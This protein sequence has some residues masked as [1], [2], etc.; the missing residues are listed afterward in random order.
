MLQVEWSIS[1][2]C[3][4]AFSSPVK[5]GPSPRHTPS[6]GFYLQKENA[7]SELTLKSCS[8]SSQS[9]I[10][11]EKS[12]PH[13]I[14][15]GG[16][17]ICPVLFETSPAHFVDLAQAYS[18]QPTHTLVQSIKTFLNLVDLQPSLNNREI[19]NRC[20]SFLGCGGVFQPLMVQGVDISGSQA[21]HQ[22]P[23]AQSNMDDST[24]LD[25]P[26]ARTPS[27]GAA[28]PCQG[29]SLQQPPRGHQE[30]C[31]LEGSKPDNPM[32]RD[33]LSVVHIPGVDNW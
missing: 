21:P 28:R 25:I 9:E 20:Q 30:S 1:K 17:A 11:H 3:S 4:P 29:Y 32:N 27:Q 16:C 15:L 7:L 23:V 5:F 12:R 33:F 31:S 18:F 10:L 22:H 19:E 8:Q 14:L 26:S 2:I 13:G 24:T 6:K